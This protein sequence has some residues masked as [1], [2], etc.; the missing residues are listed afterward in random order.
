MENNHVSVECDHCTLDKIYAV[1]SQSSQTLLLIDFR[2]SPLSMSV[3]YKKNKNIF[4][5]YEMAQLNN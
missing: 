5:N 4:T 3:I 2:F 1:W